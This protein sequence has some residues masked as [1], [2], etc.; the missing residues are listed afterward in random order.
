MYNINVPV[1]ISK[2]FHVIGFLKRG[3]NKEAPKPKD[4]NH[5]AEAVIEPNR[6]NTFSYKK[7]KFPFL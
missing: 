7:I 6:K 2:S 1:V 5:K 4:T 3:I